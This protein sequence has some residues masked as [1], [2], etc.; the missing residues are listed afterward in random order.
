MEAVSTSETS[1]SFYQ[2]TQRNIP[3]DSHLRTR[4]RENLKSPQI[5]SM[6]AAYTSETRMCFSEECNGKPSPGASGQIERQ[7]L[8]GF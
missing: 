2:I 3:Q 4:R 5:L 8:N 7:Y 6:C 1:V